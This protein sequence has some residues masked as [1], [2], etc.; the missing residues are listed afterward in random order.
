LKISSNING[1]LMWGK[2]RFME[3]DYSFNNCSG[4]MYALFCCFELELL[5][6]YY[7]NILCGNRKERSTETTTGGKHH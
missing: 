2:L 1:N 7:P 3:M 5:K 6:D 4:Q